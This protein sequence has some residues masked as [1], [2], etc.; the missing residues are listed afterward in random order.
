MMKKIGSIIIL[1]LLIGYI[2]VH[3]QWDLHALQP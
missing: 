1:F 3:A 2:P